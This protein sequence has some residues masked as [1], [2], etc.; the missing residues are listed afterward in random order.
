VH[1]A[2]RRLL[3]ASLDLLPTG[4]LVKSA[5]ALLNSPYDQVRLLPIHSHWN[6]LTLRTGSPLDIACD[7]G[8]NQDYKAERR[9]CRWCHSI[10]GAADRSAVTSV[11]KLGVTA[12][13]GRVH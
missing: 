8:P 7:T 10:I 12:R 5:E 3:L 11:Q 4:E 13:S 6:N 2:Y 9:Y 1:Q